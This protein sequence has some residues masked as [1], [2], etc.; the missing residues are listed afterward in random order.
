M[1]RDQL[2]A[3]EQGEYYWT[4]LIGLKVVTGD[5]TELGVIERLFETGAN[6]VVVVKG[7]RERLIPYLPGQVITR[8]DLKAGEMEVDWDPDF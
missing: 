1:R 8:V 6:D 2:P 7:D 3:L 5:G 4:D